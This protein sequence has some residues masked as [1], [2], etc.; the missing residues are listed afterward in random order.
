VGREIKEMRDKKTTS[1]ED[2]SVDGLKTWKKM[3]ANNNK[4]IKMCV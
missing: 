3:V 4:L 1:D 2:A